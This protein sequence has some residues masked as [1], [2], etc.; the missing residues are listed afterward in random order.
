VKTERKKPGI[1]FYVRGHH[2][3]LLICTR[4]SHLPLVD[5]V[6]P[7]SSVVEAPL[8]EHSQKP[9]VFRQTIERMYPHSKY[10]ELFARGALPKGWEGF[11]NE[12]DDR[13][14]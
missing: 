8:A 14:G 5:G 6:A 3:L 12:Y 11:G 2:E 1:G 9:E 10:L 4:G 13:E 7:L